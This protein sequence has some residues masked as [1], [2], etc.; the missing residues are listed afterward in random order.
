MQMYPTTIAHLR[1]SSDHFM[2]VCNSR[3][4]QHWAAKQSMPYQRTDE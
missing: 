2:N 1:I 3:V 4:E